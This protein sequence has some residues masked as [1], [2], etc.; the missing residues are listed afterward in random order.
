MGAVIVVVISYIV[1]FLIVG[2]IGL[3]IYFKIQ[4]KRRMEEERLANRKPCAWCRQIHYNKGSLCT[5]C[6][7]KRLKQEKGMR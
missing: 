6:C 5:E 4:E 3:A 2:G 1:I 7:I